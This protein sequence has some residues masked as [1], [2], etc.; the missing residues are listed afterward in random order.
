[1][2]KLIERLEKAGL[3]TPTL[4]GFGPASRRDSSA[5]SII[6]IGRVTPDELAKDTGPLDAQVDAFMV[7]VSSW[8]APPLDNIAAAL[9]DRLWGV[10]VNGLDGEQARRLTENGCD[11][12]V[13]D[14]DDTAAEVLND[15]DLGKVMAIGADLSEEAA[16][17]IQE[18]P[19]DGV[20]YS[21]NQDL[22]PLTV[23]KL[24]EIQQ[25]RG[26]VDRPFVMAAASELGPP[27]LES[28]RNA[29]IAGL[30]VETSS[31]EAVANTKEAIA[32]LPRRRPSSKSSDV[33]APQATT[34]L[35]M[36]GQ[37]AEEEGDDD[38][39]FQLPALS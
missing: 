34:G 2:S 25:I 10:R 1:M 14:A 21:P 24:V 13:F 32:A 37:G 29:G 6:L 39:E 9:R 7:S 8:K 5:P 3:H 22:V 18:L 19:I 38:G 12:V 11:F 23:Q 20:L 30:V 15:E 27:E 28:L 35:G 4:M 16:H 17:A 31:A 33:F 36:P 26:L